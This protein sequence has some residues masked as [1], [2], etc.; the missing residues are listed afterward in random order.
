MVKPMP[1][2]PQS[3]EAEAAMVGSLLL[4]ARVFDDV[5]TI[6]H[7]HDDLF[8]NQHKAVYHAVE[9]L[10]SAGRP[11]DMVTVK[12]WLADHNKLKEAGGVEKLIELAESVPS[13]VMA[14]TYAKTVRDKAHLRG[15]IEIAHGII[16]RASSDPLPAADQQRAAEEA[17]FALG[18]AK[19]EDVMVPL[20]EAA[21]QS[22]E[23]IEERAETGHDDRIPTGFIDIDEYLG[24]VRPGSLI[25]VAG[26]TSMGKSAL[27]MNI[28]VNMAM[29]GFPA[30]YFS[31]E[32]S[33]IE[34]ADRILSSIS[35]IEKKKFVHPR[36]HMS[37][38]DWEQLSLAKTKAGNIPLYIA[39]TPGLSLAELQSISRRAIRR[40]GVRVLFVDYLQIMEYPTPNDEVGSIRQLTGAC[41]TLAR[42]LNV[43]LFLVSQLRRRGSNEKDDRQPKLA[44]LHGSSTI[45]KDSNAVL[46]IHRPAYYHKGD[47]A[48]LECRPGIEEKALLKIEKQRNGPLASVW[49][50]WNASLTRFGNLAQGEWPLG[51]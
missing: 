27:A 50:H 48:W 5:A 26:E 25:T 3:Y 32:M 22:V 11:V 36:L 14:T 4:D 7:G 40:L 15:L 47:D 10:V 34:L 29:S 12:Q 6:L 16:A 43:P 18:E 21:K 2:L 1:Q 37:A 19:R 17:V 13:A 51:I 39:D 9:A 49:L 20:G 31:M 45:E 23:R 44:D 28:A 41:K 30:L 42:R 33:P 24:D 38:D 35:N 8:N 46:M